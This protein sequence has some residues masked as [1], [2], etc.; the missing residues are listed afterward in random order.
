[1]F[2]CHDVKMILSPQCLC[3]AVKL[4]V[5]QWHSQRTRPFY[6]L[7]GLGFNHW[8]KL[9]TLRTTE[10]RKNTNRS[11]VSPCLS[12]YVMYSRYRPHPKLEIKHLHYCLLDLF[13]Q[14]IILTSKDTFTSPTT[15]SKKLT[16]SFLS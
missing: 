4:L 16:S 14:L 5:V 8:I 13:V 9:S 12:N 6:P 7:A 3:P 1:M 11:V 15:T 10:P 2:E